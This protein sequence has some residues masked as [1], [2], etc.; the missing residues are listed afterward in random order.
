MKYFTP[1]LY[2]RGNSP[3]EKV[4]AGVE[5]DW[6]RAVRR[7]HRRLARIQRA[8][9]KQWHAFRKQHVR[10]HDAQV[11]SIT[12]QEDKLLFVLQ[13]EAPSHAIVILTFTLDGELEID[14]TALPG[15]H[16]RQP[17][18]WMYEEFDLDR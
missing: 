6:E 18:T 10:L 7:Y 1:E 14:P 13:Q 3:D 8:F 9:P 12:R 16:R 17:V 5:E 2:L 4:V 11:L 15:R